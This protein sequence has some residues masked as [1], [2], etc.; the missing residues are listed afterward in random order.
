MDGT[1]WD[2]PSNKIV[3]FRVKGWDMTIPVLFSVIPQNRRMRIG[4]QLYTSYLLSAKYLPISI[5]TTIISTNIYSFF[6]FH[7]W[8][9]H[10]AE[11]NTCG[12]LARSVRGRL[13]T[14][15]LK[16]FT[17]WADILARFVNESARFV[18]ELAHELN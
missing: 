10:M 9:L 8:P 2:D 14:A 6:V 4:R 17:S 12:S 5:S 16:F 15:R 18:N 3:W 11:W 13:G 1:G 7:S